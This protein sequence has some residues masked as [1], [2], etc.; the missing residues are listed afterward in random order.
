MGIGSVNLPTVPLPDHDG[1]PPHILR[2]TT[3]LHAPAA[4]CN[5]LG[6]PL[7]DS[8][9]IQ[10]EPHGG[11][12]R[13]QS[14]HVL[15]GCFDPTRPLRQLKLRKPPGQAAPL[16]GLEADADVS[17]E[18]MV[19]TCAWWTDEE[20]QRWRLRQLPPALQQAQAQAQAKAK[21]QAQAQAQAQ[22]QAGAQPP[23]R[24]QSQEQPHEQAQGHT[25]NKTKE[26]EKAQNQEK[27]KESS[28]SKSS[29][30]DPM[31]TAI[32]FDR[33][34]KSPLTQ[35][36]KSQVF[37]KPGPG[38]ETTGP[39]QIPTSMP[40]ADLRRKENLM[41]FKSLPEEDEL[42]SFYDMKTMQ[43][44]RHWCLAAEIESNISI[45]RTVL[46]A[47]DRSGFSMR[48]AFYTPD[49]GRGIPVQLLKRGN[50]ILIFYAEPYYFLDLSIGVRLEDPS[51][52]KVNSSPPLPHFSPSLTTCYLLSTATTQLMMQQT[53]GPR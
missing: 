35:K 52:F 29:T 45:T 9:N 53:N 11:L 6:A 46:Q 33:P 50:T 1:G 41:P 18:R 31:V 47:R 49:A 40:L 8:Y 32:S 20:R 48:I 23:P 26:E 21:A 25:E 51:L 37:S 36:P 43:P 44:R 5:I 24:T 4:L 10:L 19:G 39:R 14:T 16:A 30:S 38:R 15:V 17:V 27:E 12:I 22:E 28:Q 42:L 13:D 2:L 34:S 3:V 7:M